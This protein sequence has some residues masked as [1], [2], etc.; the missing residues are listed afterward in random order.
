MKFDDDESFVIE[1][2]NIHRFR[3]QADETG[4]IQIVEDSSTRR[5]CVVDDDT[6][7]ISQVLTVKR[8][9]V[10]PIG[11]A[12]FSSDD[13]AITPVLEAIQ[14]STSEPKIPTSLAG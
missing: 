5:A 8:F 9:I 3:Y 1:G 10:S 12:F 11:Y 4:N 7:F 13:T 14:Q 2:C 6:V